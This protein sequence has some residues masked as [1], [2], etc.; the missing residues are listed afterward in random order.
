MNKWISVDDKLPENKSRVFVYFKN[1]YGKGRRTIAEYIKG[2]TVLSEDYLDP[3]LSEDFEEYDEEND[4]YWTPSG[5]YESQ[6]ATDMNYFL[7]EKITHWMPLP[8]PP[9][10]E[11]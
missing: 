9:T 3:D 6:Y 10:E 8:K 7:H 4:C 5:Y 2:K 1:E 11:K